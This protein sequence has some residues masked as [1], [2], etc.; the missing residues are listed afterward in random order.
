M[1]TFFCHTIVV[2]LQEKQN[3]YVTL[4]HRIIYNNIQQ[5]AKTKQKARRAVMNITQIQENSSDVGAKEE[6]QEEEYNG[7]NL[8]CTKDDKY[9]YFKY[10][11]CNLSLKR[12]IKNIRY[13]W[14]KVVVSAEYY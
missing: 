4:F 3:N 13:K 2:T 14:V 5:H 7:H 11:Y 8:R 12:N 6:E 9:L 1:K 10:I